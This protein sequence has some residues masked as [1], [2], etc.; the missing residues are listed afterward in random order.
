MSPQKSTTESPPK[1]S[2]KKHGQQHEKR[3]KRPARDPEK[4]TDIID[5]AKYIRNNRAAGREFNIADS[6]IRVW[7]KNEEKIRQ[8]AETT[9]GTIQ[10]FERQKLDFVAAIDEELVRMLNAGDNRCLS[11]NGI[12]EQ[13]NVLWGEAAKKDMEGAEMKIT[14]VCEN[15]E[16][17]NANL[18]LYLSGMGGAIHATKRAFGTE[19]CTSNYC[20]NN[21]EGRE[22]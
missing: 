18:N 21:G 3:K 20:R 19:D 13:A 14:M 11:W 12:L 17:G 8:Q 22:E 9:I 2:K 6:S 10:H 4:A 7:L 1:G 16:G 5:Y 15:W